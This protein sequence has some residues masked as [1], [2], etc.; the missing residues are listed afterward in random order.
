MR[1][2]AIYYPPHEKTDLYI[3]Q[4]ALICNQPADNYEFPWRCE[5]HEKT[6]LVPS[7]PEIPAVWLSGIDVVS[8]KEL[9]REIPLLLRSA[10][11]TKSIDRYENPPYSINYEKESGEMYLQYAVFG[12]NCGSTNAI[13]V[14]KTV[15]GR[16]RLSMDWKK[17][18]GDI[19]LS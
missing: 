10:L 18:R 12:E 2:I 8:E 6:K 5:L 4:N 17:D 3:K 1:L 14:L 7:S 19:C 9:V 15:S 11:E 16:Y 13:Q